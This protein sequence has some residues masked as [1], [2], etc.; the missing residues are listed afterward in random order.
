V[1][2]HQ[3]EWTVSFNGHNGPQPLMSMCCG[4]ADVFT[5][6]Q[7]LFAESSQDAGFEVR[8]VVE[9]T[10]LPLN[11]H[12]RVVIDGV[13][14]DSIPTD[15]T[16]DHFRRRLRFSPDLVAVDGVVDGVLGKAINVT[17]ESVDFGVNGAAR[18]TVQLP[19]WLSGG[20]D[21][22]GRAGPRD[23]RV[24]VAGLAGTNARVDVESSGD[25]TVREVQRIT[26]L[27]T[28]VGEVSLGSG[29][30][31]TL[32]LVSTSILIAVTLPRP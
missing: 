11:G 25:W 10:A 21:Q 22:L 1:P 31:I 29:S 24:D 28:S 26:A 16:A 32:S 8:S 2:F 18:W 7:T 6:A 17:K 27:A 14:S 23:V 13:E 12:F 15:A 9:G 20:G 19:D 5:G 3:Y 4:A 30:F